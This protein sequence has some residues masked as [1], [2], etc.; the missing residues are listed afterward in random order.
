MS[1]IDELRDIADGP[2]DARLRG[3]VR[4]A[5]EALLAPAPAGITP[6]SFQENYWRHVH[7]DPE[8]TIAHSAVRQSLRAWPE[9]GKTNPAIADHLNE[10]RKNRRP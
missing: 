2:D 10:L 1:D 9:G 3:A 4:G 6:T 7:D 8:V 5:V